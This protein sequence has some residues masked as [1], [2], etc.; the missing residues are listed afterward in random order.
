M[1]DVDRVFLFLHHTGHWHDS[2]RLL[3]RRCVV[4]HWHHQPSD[5]VDHQRLLDYVEHGM[6][7]VP[8]LV[9]W[10]VLTAPQQAFWGASVIDKFGRRRMMLTSLSGQLIFGF[11]PWT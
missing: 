11:L 2:N 3:S 9:E 7:M 8:G 6:G 5:S 4:Q 10:I 1:A